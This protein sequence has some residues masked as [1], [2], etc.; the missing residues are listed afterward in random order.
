MGSLLGVPVF[1]KTTI[2]L[3]ARVHWVHLFGSSHSEELGILGRVYFGDQD[4]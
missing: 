2:Q 3:D 1:W 4:L